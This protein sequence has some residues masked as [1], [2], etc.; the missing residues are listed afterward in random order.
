MSLSSA[1]PGLLLEKH[2]Y[3]LWVTV[4]KLTPSC[5]SENSTG[6]ETH[7]HAS[8]GKAGPCC[9]SKKENCELI[10]PTGL[11]KYAISHFLGLHCYNLHLMQDSHRLYTWNLAQY[12]EILNLSMLCCQPAEH[13]NSYQ[14][15]KYK[16]KQYILSFNLNDFGL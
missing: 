9:H 2:F 15:P 8:H 16:G 4:F 10:C 3:V 5:Y 1:Y 12:P 14:A 6:R 13:Q 7:K 11:K